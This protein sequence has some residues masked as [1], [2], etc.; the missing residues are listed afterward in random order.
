MADGCGLGD[1][2]AVG[3]G[4][5]ASILE[6]SRIGTLDRMTLEFMASIG[7]VVVIC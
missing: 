1:L 2:G 5:E 6:I 7:L 4:V 3:I